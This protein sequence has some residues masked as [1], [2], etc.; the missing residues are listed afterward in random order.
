VHLPSGASLVLATQN[1]STL[2]AFR[3]QR[4]PS[5]KRINAR[6]LDAY[7]EITLGNGQKRRHEF[8]YGSSYLTHSSRTLVVPVGAVKITL[9]DTK[10]NVRQ[11]E[12]P[13]IQ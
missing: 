12:S 9:H 3:L 7:A 4:P 6:P 10:G 8:F 11:G 13:A 2:K 5:G 1:N